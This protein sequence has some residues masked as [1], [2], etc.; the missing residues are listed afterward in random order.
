MKNSTYKKLVKI[1]TTIGIVG[2]L[3]VAIC[4]TSWALNDNV[5]GASDEPDI[6]TIGPF[7]TIVAVSDDIRTMDDLKAT[8]DSLKNE[9]ESL[10]NE[11]DELKKERDAVA[12]NATPVYDDT[13]VD[14]YV[15][16]GKGKPK[17][18]MGYYQ[19]WDRGTRQQ[20]FHDSVAYDIRFDENGFCKL[21]ERFFVAMKPYYGE[22]G[23]CIDVYLDTGE[24]IPCIIGDNKGSE[25]DDLYVHHDGSIIEFM[26]DTSIFTRVIDVRPEF[27]HVITSIKNLGQYHK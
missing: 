15:P 9:K 10:I 12:V 17:S 6:K 26:V 7:D 14:C 16:E 4:L 23:D 5:F 13:V 1:L 22:V 27:C 2:I 19:K 20:I 18:F 8:V 11:I 3:G 21:G 25:N 24:M